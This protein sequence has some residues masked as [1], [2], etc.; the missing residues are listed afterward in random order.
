MNKGLL[1]VWTDVESGTEDDFNLWYDR[2][3]VFERAD[4]PG[5]LN[6]RRYRAIAG[7][8]RYMALYETASVEVLGGSSYKA[9]VDRP[10]SWTRRVMANFRNTARMVYA[11]RHELGRGYGGVVWTARLAVAS[12]RESSLLSWLAAEALPAAAESPGII[13][14]GLWEADGGLSGLPAGSGAAM[15]HAADLPWAVFVEGTTERAVRG[16]RDGLL[17]PAA[18]R[19]RGAKRVTVGLYRLMFGVGA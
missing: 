7:R 16:A 13:R 17:A 5:V 19:A 18:L 4:I 8:P 3:H 1:A 6:A 2:E 12:G 9:I 14:T 15:A 10:T 11:H